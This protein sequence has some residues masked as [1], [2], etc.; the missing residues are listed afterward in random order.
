MKLVQV[1]ARRL[2]GLQNHYSTSVYKDRYLFG[3]HGDGAGR[4][5]CVQ[6]DTGNEKEGWD[7]PDVGKGNLIL[8]GN[9]LII[10]TE[11][12][13]LCLV[14]ATPEDY[15]LIAKIPKVLNGNNN[16]ATPTLV[17]GKLYLRDDEKI[18]CYDVRP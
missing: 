12:G 18:V 5:K 1:Y 14:E 17:E 13:E 15:R 9:Y 6:F 10:Q 7:A 11:R 8:A 16:W 4:L 3:F 2:K